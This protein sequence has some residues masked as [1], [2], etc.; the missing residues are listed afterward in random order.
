MP[1]GGALRAV[2]R[3]PAPPELNPSTPGRNPR[4]RITTADLAGPGYAPAVPTLRLP[5][6]P[7]ADG[8]AA[9]LDAEGESSPWAVSNANPIREGFDA[10]A[11]LGTAPEGCTRLLAW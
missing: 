11:W 1:G 8:F 2:L 6:N 9:L 4:D 5:T 3:G 10:E 7:P